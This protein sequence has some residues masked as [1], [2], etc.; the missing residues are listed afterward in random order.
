MTQQP[1]RGGTT[2]PALSTAKVPATKRRSSL[3][4]GQDR[5]TAG[6]KASRTVIVVAPMT[7]PAR[8][9]Q[10]PTRTALGL[11][12]PTRQNGAGMSDLWQHLINFWMVGMCWWFHERLRRLESKRRLH[13]LDDVIRELGIDAE[14]DGHE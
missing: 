2:G 3:A 14:G 10:R 7:P 1:K 11:L 12:P 4:T 5:P 6:I 9:K 13:D 8:L